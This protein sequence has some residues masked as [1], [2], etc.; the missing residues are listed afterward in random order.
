MS[1]VRIILEDYDQELITTIKEYFTD[2]EIFNIILGLEDNNTFTT[3]NDTNATIEFNFMA[4]C[5]IILHQLGIPSNIKG[6][7]Y[8]T[9]SINILYCSKEHLAIGKIY[10]LVATRYH[11]TINCVERD[12]RNAITT[13]CDRCNWYEKAPELFGN[14][15]SYKKTKPTNMEFITA[16]VAKL[17]EVYLDL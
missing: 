16:V 13:G 8:L 6:Y 12:I 7:D 2:S 9:E 17:K 4:T 1:K 15:I 14:S 3:I 5:N 10:N 11:T